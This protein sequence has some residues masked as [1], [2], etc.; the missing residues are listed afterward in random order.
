M[1]PI[2]VQTPNLYLRICLLEDEEAE[3]VTTVQK[4]IFPGEKLLS[5]MT[6]CTVDRRKK[7]EILPKNA[8]CLFICRLILIKLGH[9]NPN[10]HRHQSLFEDFV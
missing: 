8:A 1:L 2:P 10:L 3:S 6:I 5:Q 4:K 7:R 9:Q